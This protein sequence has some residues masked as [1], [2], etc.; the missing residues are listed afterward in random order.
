[1]CIPGLECTFTDN[2]KGVALVQMNTPEINITAITIH[3]FD[4]ELTFMLYTKAG[5]TFEEVNTL[6]DVVS[7]P[8]QGTSGKTFTHDE[9]DEPMSFL[10]CG[11]GAVNSYWEKLFA[12]QS[13]DFTPFE[14]RRT[15]HVM[16]KI[17]GVEDDNDVCEV[18]TALFSIIGIVLRDDVDT[19]PA[20]AC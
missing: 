3:R 12:T 9:F 15:S 18:I 8:L 13:R 7:V 4:N 17:T 1:M 5:T 6:I 20:R 16:V 10:S 19:K 14:S 11:L 2:N